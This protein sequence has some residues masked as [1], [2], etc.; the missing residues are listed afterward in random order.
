MKSNI[1]FWWLR[2]AGRGYSA[3]VGVVISNGTMLDSNDTKYIRGVSV[4]CKI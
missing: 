2:S 3:G 4:V 1:Y